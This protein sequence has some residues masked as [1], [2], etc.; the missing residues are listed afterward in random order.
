MFKASFLAILL[1]TLAYA[2]PLDS[3]Q[4]CADVTVVFARGTGEVR[5]IGSIVGP[6]FEDALQSRLGGRSLNFV[7]VDYAATVG[8]FLQGGDPE[9]ARN[10][11]R[12]VTSVA[13]SCPD[14]AIVMSGYSQ[15]AQLVHLS[16]S[17]ISSSVQNRVNA[18]VVFGD[19]D[20]GDGFPGVLN[21]R[22]ITFCA[23]GDNICDG[24]VIVLPAHL[25]YGS[26]AGQAADFVVSRV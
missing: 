25:S 7:G 16:A 13:S 9:G 11:A 1:S 20:N 26:N 3:R 15:G 8:G 23:N 12:D 14:T 21:G 6:P 22:S 18:V 4:A 17:Q 24:G 10:M 19:P 2:A 5:P